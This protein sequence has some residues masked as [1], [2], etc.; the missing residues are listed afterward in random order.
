[1]A[2]AADRRMRT[3]L[4]NLMSIHPFFATLALRMP[5]VADP[6]KK[7]V[8]CDGEHIYYNP[9]WVSHEGSDKLKAAIARLVM[10]CALKHHTRRGDRDYAKWQ[11]ASNIVTLP[12][13]QDAGLDVDPQVLQ[14][15]T[16]GI[17]TQIEEKSVEE[18]YKLIPDPEDD[19]ESEN[20][21]PQGQQGGGGGGGGSA[22]MM[23]QAGGN[24]PGKGDQDGDGQG[25]GSGEGGG[26]GQGQP[27]QGQGGQGQGGDQQPES[28]DATGT[29]EIMDSPRKPDESQAD[30]QA[31]LKEAEQA[32]D[33]AGQQALQ[34]AHAQ[35][36]GRTPGMAAELINNAHGG[37]IDWRTEL[38]RFMTAA[39]RADYSWRRP[40]R[41][42]IDAGIYLPAIHSE[43]MPAIVLAID[44][45]ASLDEAQLGELWSEMRAA[46]GDVEPESVTVIQCDTRVTAIDEYHHTDMPVELEAC[47]RGGTRFSPVF[48]AI[49]EMP[50]RPACVIYFTDMG[51][52]D[53]GEDPGVPVLWAV[54]RGAWGIGYSDVPFGEMI[55]L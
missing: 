5:M 26:Q 46:V 31:S 9:D 18:V 40:N 8:A 11:Q 22:V 45:S 20:Q 29:G 16:A 42:F 55:E 13:L 10:A 28:Q 38:R 14:E 36:E 1:M 15:L 35:G 43:G 17:M 23:V 47:G 50:V 34:I 37:K 12:I 27:Q 24:D 44:T 53:Y 7:T 19:D 52:S 30:Y 54:Q 39:A 33:K 32:W 3:A 48:E 51:S 41:R 4:R 25:D 49:R 6:R 21:Q 2:T